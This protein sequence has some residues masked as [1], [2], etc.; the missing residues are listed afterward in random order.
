[1]LK[2]LMYSKDSRYHTF[3]VLVLGQAKLDH[4]II[5]ALNP[6]RLSSITNTP[7]LT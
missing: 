2:L 3:E 7:E 1:M 5:R 4:T 6:G